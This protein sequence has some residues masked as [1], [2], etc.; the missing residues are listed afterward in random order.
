MSR[1]N[2]QTFYPQH[3][4]RPCNFVC[5]CYDE[6]FSRCCSGIDMLYQGTEIK[7]TKVLCEDCYKQCS[8]GQECQTK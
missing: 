6:Q 2:E 3:G 7:Y 8:S 4:C 5:D 1:H